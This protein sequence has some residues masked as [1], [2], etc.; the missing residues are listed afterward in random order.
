MNKGKKT[1]KKVLPKIVRHGICFRGN[2]SELVG[3]EISCTCGA[4]LKVTD[5]KQISHEDFPVVMGDMQK[6]AR[7]PA[8]KCPECGLPAFI[9][10]PNKDS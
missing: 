3:E 2:F 6:T 4:I 8:V 7:W 5:V 1:P 10:P 9:N